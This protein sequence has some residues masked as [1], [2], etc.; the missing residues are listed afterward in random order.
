MKTYITIVDPAGATLGYDGPFLPVSHR[1]LFENKVFYGWEGINKLFD[2][3]IDLMNL[4][5]DLITHP[6]GSTGKY[7]SLEWSVEK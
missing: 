2:Q 3:H 5:N 7:Q 4:L 6:N 1:I